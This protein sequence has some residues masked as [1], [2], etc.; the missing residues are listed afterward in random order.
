MESA[1]DRI[2]VLHV[3]DDQGLL[4]VAARFIE[5]ANKRLDVTTATDADEGLSCLDRERVDC[6]IF[7]YKMPGRDGQEFLEAVRE[8]R[9]ELPFILFTGKGSEEIASEAISAGVTNYRQKETGTDQYRVLA[10]NVLN[11]VKRHRSRRQLKEREERLSLYFEQS[12]M[13]IIEWDLNFEFVRMN[14]IAEEILGYDAVNLAGD[15]WEQISPPDQRETVA[16]TFEKLF[17]DEG[18]YE[19]TNVNV[20]ASGDRVVCEWHNRVITDRDGEVVAVL[21]QFQDVTEG[22]ENERDLCRER[23]RFKTLFDHLPVAAVDTKLIDRE[24]IVQAV[25]PA[26]E[27][28]FGFD[29]EAVAGE[30]IDKYIIPPGSPATPSTPRCWRTAT[31]SGTSRDGTQT[32]CGSSTSSSRSSTTPEDHPRRYA[33]YL[34]S[35]WEQEVRGRLQAV[36]EAFPDLGFVVDADG[37][38]LEQFVGPNSDDV[39]VEP[40]LVG[41]QFHD[42]LPADIA[43]DLLAAVR[44][45]LETGEPNTTEY[46]LDV[47]AGHHTFEARMAPHRSPAG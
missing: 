13:G 29:A 28:T 6:I 42:L 9:P 21:S 8:T 35:T 32:V 10:R 34:D 25:N 22:V 20:T 41:R 2:R 7:D 39:M 43:D 27:E 33:I 30:N 18:G 24:P 11:A 14:P 17:A 4:E 23:D 31:T 40:D 19:T 3:D 16:A 36:M 37:Q 26:F 5:R 45:T 44:A 1:G 38:F 46:A 47:P 15:S 12:P